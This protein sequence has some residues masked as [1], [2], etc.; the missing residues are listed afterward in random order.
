MRRILATLAV[1]AL[2][3]SAGCGGDKEPADQGAPEGT[4]TM[5]TPEKAPDTPQQTIEFTCSTP[6]CDKT[7]QVAIGTP[8]PS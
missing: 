8:P 4:P 6:D 2:V 3:L 7:K 1:V 5:K